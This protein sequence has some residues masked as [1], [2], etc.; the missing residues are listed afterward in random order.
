[1]RQRLA[2]RA[3]R[4]PRDDTIGI[5]TPLLGQLIT[6][7]GVVTH[8]TDILAEVRIAHQA[9]VIRISLAV[10]PARMG[11]IEIMTDLV[12]DDGRVLVVVAFV[13][14]EPGVDSAVGCPA[15]FVAVAV[16]ETVHD[17]IEG[18]G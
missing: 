1:M 16:F 17:E 18:A 12:H 13:D 2:A 6:L 15:A 11:Q 5:P 9:T 14:G 4:I 3:A 8:G 10:G 7:G